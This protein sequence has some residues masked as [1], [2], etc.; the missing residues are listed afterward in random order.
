M[1]RYYCGGVH[2]KYI[3]QGFHSMSEEQS[4]EQMLEES[5]KTTIRNGEVVEGTVLDVKPDVAYLNI[6]FKSDGILTRG[7]IQQRERS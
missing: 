6:G 5:L 4:F 1:C 2:P 3:I 7:R